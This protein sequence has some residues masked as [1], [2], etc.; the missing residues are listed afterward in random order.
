MIVSDVR[1][2][3][4][5]SLASYHFLVPRKSIPT[6][7]GIEDPYS[8]RNLVPAL[9]FKSTSSPYGCR[10]RRK[11]EKTS[12]EQGYV[13]IE[14]MSS[15]HVCLILHALV[16]LLSPMRTDLLVTYRVDFLPIRMINAV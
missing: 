5:N 10:F 16:I 14:E 11:I 4:H 13:F 1:L 2:D 15:D 3:K 12:I 9:K 8:I 6:A 7:A